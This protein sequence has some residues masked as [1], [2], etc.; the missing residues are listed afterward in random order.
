MEGRKLRQ[1][2]RSVR[3]TG[4]QV[5]VVRV[6]EERDGYSKRVNARNASSEGHFV[7]KIG[8]T[9]TS[10]HYRGARNEIEIEM[11]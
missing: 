8:L 11:L 7:S 5:M 10:F 4:S 3:S 1:E 6:T 2:V 9:V